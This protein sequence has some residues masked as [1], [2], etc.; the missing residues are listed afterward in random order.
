[1][2]SAKQVDVLHQKL[3][4]KSQELDRRLEETKNDSKPV[5]LGEPIGRLSRMDAMQQQQVAAESKRRMQAE[6]SQVQAALA[7][8]K[9]GSYGL[10]LRCEEPIEYKRLEVRPECTLCRECQSDR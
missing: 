10:C 2:L 8:I 4:D 5:S 7:R 9:D 6:R 3:R 1:M